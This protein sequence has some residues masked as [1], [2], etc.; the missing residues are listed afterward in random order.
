M[1][2]NKD[3]WSNVISFL[4]RKAAG[5][6]CCVSKQMRLDVEAEKYRILVDGIFSLD[7][8]EGFGS[9]FES[10]EHH[11]TKQNALKRVDELKDDPKITFV[12]L[13][14]Y[15]RCEI[16]W[17]VNMPTFSQ[18]WERKIGEEWVLVPES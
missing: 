14:Q 16:G 12:W 9:G 15:Y 11:L 5:R 10:M 2:M 6:L 4:T 17:C 18:K 1:A 8:P 3:C 13:M 7:Y